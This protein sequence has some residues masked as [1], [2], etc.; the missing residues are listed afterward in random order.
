MISP[1][2]PDG[3]D[4]AL[5][6]ALSRRSPGSRRTSAPSSPWTR[7]C[8]RWAIRR[9]RSIAHSVADGLALIEDFGAA[10]I[11]QQRRSRRRALRRGDRAAR[12]TA[13]RATCRRAAVGGRE[14]IRSADL[15]HRGDADRGRA[16]ARLVRA[17]D[18]A[19]CA[20]VGRAHAV[21]GAL[22]RAAGAGA[23]PS[24]TTWTLRDYHSPNLHWLAER[25][26][27]KRLG[28]IDFQ[29]AVLG[30][31]AYDVASLLQDARVD[32][33]DD[34]EM[35]LHGPLHATQAAADPG[36]DAAAS[37]PPMR[38][39]ARSGRPR[40]SACSPGSTS[41]TAS[42]NICASCRASSASSRA[43]SPIPCCS[44][45]RLVRDPPA[46]RARPAAGRSDPEP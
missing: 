21:P 45:S 7:A 34:L 28:L 33:P 23:R 24:P 8:A 25:E 12:R 39:W 37:P 11:A 17:G 26:G 27:L 3:P 1:P 40:S 36:F 4:A 30:P 22:A 15:R 35:R 2:R 41:A 6:Q 31:P 5:R 13:R 16:G 20:V 18:R 14:P 10:T 38:S 32:V 44:R 19:R 43:T 29:D 46:A 9:R 42:R